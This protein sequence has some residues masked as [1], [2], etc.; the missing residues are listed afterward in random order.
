MGI[1]MVRA[2][3]LMVNIYLVDT[4]L[5]GPF[6]IYLVVVSA[7]TIEIDLRFSYDQLVIWQQAE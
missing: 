7:L 6:L 4:E 1:K 5:I 2:P 3:T